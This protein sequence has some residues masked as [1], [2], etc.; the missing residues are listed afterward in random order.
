[1]P[2]NN[3]TANG[4]TPE[5]QQA[6][7]NFFNQRGLLNQDGANAGTVNTGGAS[8]LDGRLLERFTRNNGAGT[9]VN[10]NY[11]DVDL[12]SALNS[13]F[14]NL[15]IGGGGAG[16]GGGNER[17]LENLL[18]G[19]VQSD[20]QNPQN[21]QLD[22]RFADQ[23]QQLDNLIASLESLPQLD[24]Q[25]QATL[26]RLRERRLN[27]FEAAS[28]QRQGDLLARLFGSGVQQSTI[29]GEAGAE[30]TKQEA[31]GRD[32]ILNSLDQ[33]GLQL[34]A[35]QGQYEL[36][37]LQERRGLLNDE[38][39]AALGELGIQTQAIQAERDRRANLL[40][41]IF[42]RRT[43]RSIASLQARTSTQNNLVNAFVS[44]L[45]SERQYQADVKRIDADTSL[46][47]SSLDAQNAASRRQSQASTIASL[48]TLAIGIAAIAS[49]ERIKD[50]PVEVETLPGNIKV[51]EWSWVNGGK[52]RGAIAQQV[53]QQCAY[54]VFEANG[55]KIIDTAALTRYIDKAKKKERDD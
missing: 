11:Q 51:Y 20:A 26:D 2:T 15:N 33:V 13:F 24:E 38:Q 10:V 7:F 19:L 47:R 16:G 53:E 44:N 1:M 6:L 54:C 23:A 48:A 9:S 52:G 30:F 28:K 46:G 14:Q 40:D 3:E 8:P 37:K 12:A 55:L 36:Q 4:L 42:N 27:S 25:T 22:P 17:S 29:A 39:Q 49:D 45:A 31:L 5:Q 35:Q 32:E 50:D 43:Q 21:P 41:N 34:R 18:S